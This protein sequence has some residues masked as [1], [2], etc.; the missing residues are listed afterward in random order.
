MGGCSRGCERGGSGRRGGGDGPAG[1]PDERRPANRLQLFERL[2]PWRPPFAD[3]LDLGGRDLL[4]DLGIAAL[5]AQPEALE[6]LA[7]G[8]L[9]LLG[10]REMHAKPKM[11]GLVIGGA[12]D[13]LRLRRERRHILGTATAGA[14]QN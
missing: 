1:M 3:R 5:G 7:A 11:I 14:D 9:A 2:L 12:E 6:E 4:V 10:L 8:G 13:F